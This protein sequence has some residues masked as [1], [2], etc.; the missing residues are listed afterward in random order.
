MA[1][2]KSNGLITRRS[3]VQSRVDVL[4]PFAKALMFITKSLGEELKLLVSWLITCKNT[5]AFLATNNA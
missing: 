2:W 4:V 5:Y 3:S 1:Q